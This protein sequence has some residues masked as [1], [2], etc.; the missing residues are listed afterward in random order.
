MI[1]NE[2]AINAIFL[3]GTLEPLTVFL[4]NLFYATAYLKVLT[5]CKHYEKDTNRQIIGC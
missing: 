2:N 5:A 1:R 4:K 3:Y